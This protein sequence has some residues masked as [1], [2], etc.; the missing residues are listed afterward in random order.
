MRNQIIQGDALSVLK[1]MPDNMVDCVVTSPPY[2][3]LRDYGIDGQLGL[4]KTPDEYISKMVEI[5]REVRRV[6]KPDGTCWL[7][8]G[9]SYATQAGKGD[10]VPQT[11]WR[12]NTYPNEAPHRSN[13]TGGTKT[14]LQQNRNG[15]GPVY[16]LKPKDM[17]GIPWR[18]ALALQA[19]GWWLRS[20]IIWSKPNPMPESVTDR[21][22]K[23]H[24]YLFLLTKSSRYYFDQ[25]AVR[26]PHS[27]DWSK[28]TM[29]GA[30][31]PNGDW[32]LRAKTPTGH[33]RQAKR[34]QM[35]LLGRNI[36]SV[37]E[38]K[39]NNLW[40][41]MELILSYMKEI[42]PLNATV[43]DVLKSVKEKKLSTVWPVS[44]QPFPE[45]HFATFPEALVEP[46]I[47]AGTS[48]KGYCHEC[49]KPWVRVVEKSRTF[50]SGSGRSGRDPVGKNGLG[51]QGGGETGDIRRG[52]C[53]Q[54]STIGWQP[55]CY[56]IADPIPGLV[57]DPFSGSGTVAVV[58]K[59]LLRDYIGIELN[60]AYISMAK[61]RLQM[62]PAQLNIF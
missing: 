55:S 39:E 61:K 28:E 23:S 26:E 2:W 45:A 5:F 50:E 58:A 40:D 34:P 8:L 44:T 52:P 27:R 59:R 54:S 20:D 10:N 41:S 30:L 11:K 3:G 53:V 38:I 7:N 29:G 51:L 46:C 6:L 56:C 57:F 42:L 16:G 21:P 37:L 12:A 9:D 36:R 13:L 25:E 22:T 33:K 62:T 31:R 18:V 4:E 49:G 17:C 1:T 14:L 15:V 19:D 60:P 32:T 24:E 35:N 47:K 43:Q 48:E